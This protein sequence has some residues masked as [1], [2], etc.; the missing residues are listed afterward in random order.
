M[1]TQ[2]PRRATMTGIAL[3]GATSRAPIAI[4]SIAKPRADADILRTWDHRQCALAEIEARG[5]YFDAEQESPTQAAI[6]DQ[7]DEQIARATATT[8]RGLLAQAWVALSYVQ[9]SFSEVN[10]R[11]NALIRRADYD[12]LIAEG[13][14]LDWEVQTQLAVIRSLRNMTG[15]G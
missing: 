12:G 1:N 10:R 4:A 13:E 8:L 14:Y 11:Q 7:A 9:D 15:E 5:D 3:A 2:L 6:Y